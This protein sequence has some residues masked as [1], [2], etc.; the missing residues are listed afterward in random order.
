M[1]Q[2]LLPLATLFVLVFTGCSDDLDINAGVPEA[3][4]SYDF[5]AGARNVEVDGEIF[6]DGNV[7]IE[8]VELEIAM[9]DEYGHYINSVFQTLWV[10]LRPQDSFVFATDV[11]EVGVFD[12][13]VLL[14]RLN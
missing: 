7:H 11:R 13:E 3:S 2:I 4:I 9:Y 12:V 5:W 8:S 14:H 1:R 10:D 6:N